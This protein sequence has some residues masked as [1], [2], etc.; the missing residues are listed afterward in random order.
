MLMG[1]ESSMTVP[2]YSMPYSC[3]VDMH[4]SVAST[5]VFNEQAPLSDASRFDIMTYRNPTIS[6]ELGKGQA[7]PHHDRQVT[8]AP[9][10][11]L[12]V[13]LTLPLLRGVPS[14]DTPINQQ[15]YQVAT[16][17]LRSSP[18]GGSPWSDVLR[19]PH[20]SLSHAAGF[21]S[22][23]NNVVTPYPGQHALPT[24]G[25][26]QVG[27][28]NPKE[29][30]VSSVDLRPDAIRKSQRLN[31]LQTD[32]NHDSSVNNNPGSKGQDTNPKY[33][34]RVRQQP[35][36][37]RSCGFGE[38]DR[39][40]VDPP[41]IVQLHV[42]G[43]RLVEG[44]IGELLRYPQY[45][46]SCSIYDESGSQDFSLMPDH[47]QQRR[48]MGSLVS[49]PFVGKDEFDKEG[50][51]FCF[52]DLSCR[53]PGSFRLKFSLAKVDVVRAAE[54]KHFPVLAVVVSDVFTV[55]TAKDFPGMEASTR[56]I[57]CLKEQGCIIPIKKGNSGSKN[58]LKRKRGDCNLS[59]EEQE[60]EVPFVSKTRP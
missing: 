56:L 15:G 45:V 26:H 2:L 21:S 22:F 7:R 19:G 12:S 14:H 17:S 4:S 59:D 54:V 38:K 6:G 47:Q 58:K 33:S 3:Y 49:A 36:A 10:Q 1:V 18:F 31:L 60:G 37:A 8:C 41:P 53:T 29:H 25:V 40:M 46:V 52:P 43:L 5:I 34:L 44:V 55:Y 42:E 11:P 24:A 57:K 27:T 39:R 30:L 23:I 16:Q 35:V 20:G 28:A 9:H 13:P 50:C 32:E 48:L 51:F